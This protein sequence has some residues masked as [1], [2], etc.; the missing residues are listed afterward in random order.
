M[1]LYLC[2]HSVAINTGDEYGSP[3]CKLPPVYIVA[4]ALK[5][6]PAEFPES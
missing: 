3:L 2:A 6:H 4:D 1:R 5:A